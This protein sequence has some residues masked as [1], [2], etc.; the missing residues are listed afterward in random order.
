MQRRRSLALIPGQ[1]ILTVLIIEILLL[2]CQRFQWFAFSHR[3][4]WL[5]LM[6]VAAICCVGIFLILWFVTAKCLGWRFQFGIRTMF[7]AMAAVA[8]PLT[9]FIAEL[10]EAARQREAIRVISESGGIVQYQ[11]LVEIESSN[12]WNK[13]GNAS[14]GPPWLK[15][16][17]GEDFFADITSVGFVGPNKPGAEALNRLADLPR[18]QELSLQGGQIRDSDLAH[19]ESLTELRTLIL[20]NAEIT[21]DAIGY[22]CEMK[23][24]ETLSLARTHIGS[25]G[26]EHLKGLLTL[27]TLNLSETPANDAAPTILSDLGHLRELNLALT[28]ISDNAIPSL[29]TFTQLQSLILSGDLI[30]DAGIPFLSTCSNLRYLDL[31]GTTISDSG[32]QCL[33]RMHTLKELDVSD[34]GVTEAGLARIQAALPE[35]KIRH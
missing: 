20:A 30:S 27:K 8:I 4:G 21:N 2:L 31:S 26:L 9:W 35:C 13:I 17:L 29:G 22:L 32:L 10:R 23:R 16:I 25:A 5:V 3:K 1:F 14:P 15:A 6:S 18:L 11:Y 19:I 7:V 28:R 33:S 34:T 24:L 12:D